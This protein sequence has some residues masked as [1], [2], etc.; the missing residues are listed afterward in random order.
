MKNNQTAK[1]PQLL[2]VTMEGENT[3]PVF[4]PVFTLKNKRI[5]FENNDNVETILGNVFAFWNKYGGDNSIGNMPFET[6]I[7]PVF[8]NCKVANDFYNEYGADVTANEI[9]FAAYLIASLDI[10]VC[11]QETIETDLIYIDNNGV[12]YE[13]TGGLKDIGE[14]ARDYYIHF[15]DNVKPFEAEKIIQDKRN[16]TF[17]SKLQAAKNIELYFSLFGNLSILQLMKFA[18]LEVKIKKD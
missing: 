6:R 14:I 1:K 12:M 11:L 9:L 8:T 7:N 18:A 5:I 4:F 13:I 2:T 3:R 17:E 15:S 10:G 16:Y